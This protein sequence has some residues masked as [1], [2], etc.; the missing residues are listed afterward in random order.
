MVTATRAE[1]FI[2]SIGVNTSVDFTDSPDWTNTALIIS[3]LNYLGVDHVREE[4]PVTNPSSIGAAPFSV[5]KSMMLQGIKFDFEVSGQP[6]DQQAA[7]SVLDTLESAVPGGISAIE[8][9]N[10]IDNWPVTY[11]GTTG[12]AAAAAAQQELYTAVK[13]D[14]MLANIP[15]YDLSHGYIDPSLLSDYTGRADYENIHV[16]PQSG[17]QPGTWISGEQGAEYS[18]VGP[19]VITEFGY[20][21]YSDADGL[22][23]QDD[24]Y[25]GGVDSS[26]QGK[27]ILNGL[28][29]ALKQGYSM[30]YIYNLIDAYQSTSPADYFGLFN[31]NGTPKPSAIDIHNLTSIL[32]DTASNAQSFNPG[33]LTYSISNLPVAGNSVLLE[34]ASG[35][36]DLVLWSEAA[37]WNSATDTEIPVAPSNVTVTFASNLGTIEIFDPTLG[38]TPTRT[39]TNVN[40]ITVSLSDHPIIIEIEPAEPTSPASPSPNGTQITSASAAPIIDQSG[41]A[42]SLVQS[43]S[44]GLQIAVNGTVDAITA[45]VVLL[46]TLNG[47]MVQ[48][49]TAGNWSSETTPNNSWTQIANPNPARLRPRPL[50]LSQEVARTRWC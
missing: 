9:F 46:E 8:G 33:A 26:I 1:T 10:E 35:A 28:F 44:N 12:P 13:A 27:L 18:V 16:Y 7:I 30:T 4:E 39:L 19:R 6:Y 24:G 36:F 41:N 38:S 2:Q 14:P 49:N 45:N 5:Y 37:D 42:W 20:Y 40:Q 29:D 23:A 15:V 43:S 47:A 50:A 21:T 17:E 22:V 48:E 34:K 32:A 31:F 11:N 25:W 3:S